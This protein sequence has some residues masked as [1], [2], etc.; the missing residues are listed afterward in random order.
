M[1]D[2]SIP[3]SVI[4]GSIVA[5]VVIFVIVGLVLV[6]VF[7]I[8]LS[9]KGNGKGEMA[10]TTVTGSPFDKVKKRD[11]SKDRKTP[12]KGIYQKDLASSSSDKKVDM[13]LPSGKTI[14]PKFKHD[15]F[16][17]SASCVEPIVQK[18]AGSETISLTTN[19][20]YGSNPNVKPNS[21]YFFADPEK[22]KALNKHVS[23]SVEDMSFEKNPSY[24]Q[25]SD[26]SPNGEEEYSYV[27]ST[28][29]STSPMEKFRS[30]SHPPEAIGMYIEMDMAQGGNVSSGDFPISQKEEDTYI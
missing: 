26:V 23:L 12:Q 4:A 29:S 13:N 1:E 10:S 2:S 9:K 25:L 6:L 8:V 14:D 3:V 24:L 18:V 5:V 16:T 7:L 15:N 30:N 19:D 21:A 27:P 22:K 28:K 17:D 20:A 11:N